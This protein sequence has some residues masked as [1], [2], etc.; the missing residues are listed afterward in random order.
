[1]STRRTKT[2]GTREPAGG[3][4]LVRGRS[5]VF[6]A[7][8]ALLAVWAYAP[9]F[10]G[11]FIY[12]D[13]VAIAENPNIRSL[14]PL[15]SALSAPP[16]SPVS[17][18]PIASLSLAINY[19]LA[20]ADVRNVMSPAVPGAALG[21]A[22]RFFRNIWGYHA[23]NLTLHI[24]A[25]LA[26]AGVVRRTLLTHSLR[27]E[28]GA[29]ATT[30]GFAAAL[31]WVVHPLTTDAVT[32]VAQRTEVLMGLC[33]FLTLY[34][35]IRAS[36]RDRTGTSRRVWMIAAT[37]SCAAGMGSK[38]TMVT[39]PIVVWLWD[40]I[41]LSSEGGMPLD[42]AQ[43]QPALRPTRLPLY[44]GLAATWLL[45]AALVAYERW[46]TSIGF[47]LE[48][49][50]PWT[51]LLTQTSVVAHYARLVF[52]GAPL[53]VDY[54]GW[55]MIRSVVVAA[56]YAVPLVA[57]L[58]ITVFGVIKKR[59]WSFP[60]VIW[61]AA[62]APSSSVLPLATEIAADRRAYVP[63]AGVIALF[64]VG[65]FTIGRRFARRSRVSRPVISVAAVLVVVALVAMFSS[66]T[67]ARNRD[68]WS[69]ESIWQDTVEKRP[70][71]SR[72]RVN[73]ASK[74]AEAG[75]LSEA[76]QQLRE[77]VR[78]KDTNAPAHLNLGSVLCTRGRVEE[79]VKHLERA[80]ALDPRYTTVYQNLGEA[81]GAM[82]NRALAAKYF[83]LAVDAHPD[84]PFLLNR[85]GWL[86]ATSPEDNVRDGA[87]AAAISL[88]AVEATKRQ[89]AASLDTLAA[90][91]AELGRFAE[92]AAIAR[93][94]ADLAAR[95]G[96]G[97]LLAEVRR[98]AA[99]YDTQQ[100]YR[101]RTR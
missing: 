12:D 1:M 20:P 24:L 30:L 101:E 39:A 17:A 87:K 10:K 34:C 29:A 14:W 13:H 26:F 78:L 65:A 53:S 58:A 38:Q 83:S 48:G 100:K 27:D 61:F 57:L 6:T 92:A 69:E 47:A 52:T 15:S 67:Y 85:L 88:R 54:D 60:L 97:P 23:M 86:L 3:A 4:R 42:R 55:P 31:V 50:T 99:L 19:A 56:P 80:L 51:Y 18:R 66:M 82:G 46:P 32:Y 59:A 73:Y 16:E 25:A 91:Y 98:R 84:E 72:A 70:A 71:N 37:V 76:E 93:E 74:L 95:Q 8:L 94:A 43:S 81:Y 9:S 49:W 44:A 11:V 5:V 77:A 64:I 62:L 75:R 35:S 28:F 96:Q 2:R 33:Y 40:W 90:A 36:E 45:L 7:F 89:D 79:C 63:L 41:F 21:N 22:E 68:F